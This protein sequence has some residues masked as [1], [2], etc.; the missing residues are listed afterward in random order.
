MLR[1]MSEL[2]K[3]VSDLL[4]RLQDRPGTTSKWRRTPSREGD[5]DALSREREA[6]DLIR[7][8]I[9]RLKSL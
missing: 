2:E 7:R 1:A 3:A 8:A 4:E 9:K 6:A 5:E